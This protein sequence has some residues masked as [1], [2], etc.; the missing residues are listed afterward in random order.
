[1][2]HTS[3]GFHPPGEARLAEVFSLEITMLYPCDHR[4]KVATT[5][6]CKLLASL[7]VP[8]GMEH[9]YFLNVLHTHWR[10]RLGLL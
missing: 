10:D 6:S 8:P 5:S 3:R 2:S 7:S 4:D 1:M 9:F